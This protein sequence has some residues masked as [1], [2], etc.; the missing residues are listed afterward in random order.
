MRGGAD[1]DDD[2][3]IGECLKKKGRIQPSGGTCSTATAGSHMEIQPHI[4]P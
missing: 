3:W 4:L 1:E 2:E